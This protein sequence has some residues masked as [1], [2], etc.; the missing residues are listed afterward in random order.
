MI[1]KWENVEFTSTFPDPPV[2]LTQVQTDAGEA[3]LSTRQTALTSTGFQLAL[4]PEEQITSQHELESVGYLAIEPG[5]GVWSGMPYEALTTEASFTSNWATLKFGQ[6]YAQP[7][8]F[9]AS[10][11]SYNDDDNA[12]LR[13]R[14]LGST[15]VRLNVEEDTTRDTAVNHTGAESVGYLA[16]E[17]QG[18][19]AGSG[20]EQANCDFSAG[21]TF[22]LALF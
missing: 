2:V 6:T 8:S 5:T 4:E 16:L 14:D 15:S 7:P 12:H 11:A 21:S 20:R 19:L 22:L 1:P 13:F 10:L 18:L 17:G 3:F 9:L